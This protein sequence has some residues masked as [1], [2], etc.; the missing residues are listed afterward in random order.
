MRIPETLL[1]RKILNYRQNRTSWDGVV[2]SPQDPRLHQGPSKQLL[3]FC[4]PAG[5]AGWDCRPA[6]DRRQPLSRQVIADMRYAAPPGPLSAVQPR[7]S[8]R[9][10][11]R[12]PSALPP[13]RG[14][15]GRSISPPPHVDLRRRRVSAGEAPGVEVKKR[16]ILAALENH[17]EIVRS[18]RAGHRRRPFAP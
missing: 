8:S 9:R 3:N 7:R 13:H 14:S 16:A 5:I 18:R 10:G 11:A 17:V 12:S 4:D 6:S 1:C 2:I 15:R